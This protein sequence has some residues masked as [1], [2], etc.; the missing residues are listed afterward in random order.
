MLS[1]LFMASNIKNILN[2]RASD[3]QLLFEVLIATSRYTDEDI[4]ILHEDEVFSTVPS[5][6][7]T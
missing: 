5:L 1:F 7:Q 4:K 2:S 3:S 6:Q